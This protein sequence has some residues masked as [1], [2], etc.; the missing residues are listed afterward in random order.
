MGINK[1]KMF[2]GNRNQQTAHRK[3]KHKQEYG[4][5]EW[6]KEALSSSEMSTCVY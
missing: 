1:T 5:L 4:H 6:V 2:T 3:Q